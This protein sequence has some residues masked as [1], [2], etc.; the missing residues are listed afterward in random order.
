[1][2]INR[3]VKVASLILFF[4]LLLS[5]SACGEL[6]D[7]LFPS[8]GTYQ[9]KALVNDSLLE[10][11]SI[12]RQGDKIVPYF[13]VSV[14]ND[15]DLMGLL[16]YLQNPQGDIIGERVLYTV[17]PVDEVIQP[18]TQEDKTSKGKASEGEEAEENETAGQAEK[19]TSVDARSAVKKYDKVIRIKSFE[20]EMP[21]FPLPKNM[22]PGPYSLVFK[23]LGR[24]NTLSLT[25]EDIF[26]LGSVKFNLK[27]ISISLPWP[28]DTGLIPPGAVVMLEAGLDFDSSLNPYVVWYN[29]RNIIAEGSISEG[30]GN[31][32]WKA[33]EKPG[34]YSLRLEVLPNLLKRNLTG[35]FREITL[36]VSAKASQTG[37]FFENAAK[38]PLAVGTAPPEQKY[39]LAAGLTANADKP[40]TTS[41]PEL[42]RWYRFDGNLN[43]ANPIPE[44]MFESASKKA[45]RWA[46]VG[47]SYGLSAGPDDI[48]LLR[49]IRFFRQGQN[50][51]GG[52]F[53]FHISPISEG[54]IFSAFFPTLASASALASSNDGV[55]MDMAT[56]ENAITLHLKTKETSVEIPIN[57][58]FSGGQGLIPI[59]VEFYI[60]PN[61]FEARCGFGED[62]S[63]QS[64]TGW[65]ELPGALAG[66]G[67]IRLGA[68]K[69][70]PDSA[71]ET[72]S[73]SEPDLAGDIPIETI[74][75]S[76][77]T[78][79]DEFAVLYSATPILSDE[80][81]VEE[82]IRREAAQRRESRANLPPTTGSE[83]PLAD[84]QAGS[85]LMEHAPV[86]N[87]DEEVPILIS[88]Q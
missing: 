40:A 45:P 65:I 69:T 13:A 26:Y 1:M 64:I 58:N 62:F 27:D 85:I 53:L 66:E 46:A 6:G 67:R 83:T 11:C 34:F 74:Q 32:L 30:A 17:N 77:A 33:P 9:V 49:P 5:L 15:P 14:V 36:P 38:R 82:T 60:Q 55:W 43:E 52:V 54:N 16:V 61:R 59:A 71:A 23:T 21:S 70:A 3:E 35:L 87:E 57:I 63:T 80:I 79:W 25:E 81:L 29:G 73:A 42:L 68:D 37:F 18:E 76:V 31:I 28:S 56:R 19:Q 86:K 2:I 39:Q 10:S 20:H 7:S 75:P 84:I 47:Q 50:Q 44:R 4:S 88:L 24:S 41:D 48:Y 22:E 72:K 51:G 78:I 12:I 8:G